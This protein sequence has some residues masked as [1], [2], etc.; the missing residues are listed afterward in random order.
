MADPIQIVVTDGIAQTIAPNLQGVANAAIEANDATVELQSQITKFGGLTSAAS[1]S[2]S[3][4]DAI[5]ASMSAT[6][7]ALNPAFVSV[8]E[9]TVAATDAL[10]GYTQAQ[11]TSLQAQQD[12]LNFMNALN[13]S[14]GL[15]STVTKSA[16]DSAKILS[17]ALDAE[18]AAFAAVAE[19]L[20]VHN[21]AILDG[22]DLALAYRASILAAAEADL[23]LADASSV[24][25]ASVLSTADASGKGASAFGGLVKAAAAFFAITE[26]VKAIDNYTKLTNA[27]TLAGLSGQNAANEFNYLTNLAEDNGVA[28]A[29]VTSLYTK[30]LVIQGQ[31]HLS[32]SDLNKI[33][34]SLTE[35]FRI[36]GLGSA[37]V[38]QTLRDFT[39]IL[40]GNNT[41]L[42]R[43]V[44][45]LQRADPA[46]FNTVLKQL[47]LSASQLSAEL[48]D[49]TLSIANFA[50]AVVQ[51]EPAMQRLAD[52]THITVTGALTDLQ[53]A[54]TQL[55]S[56]A[57]NSTGAISLV[58]QSIQLL[59]EN[60]PLVATLVTVFGAAWAGAKLVEVAGTLISLTKDLLALEITLGGVD[61]GITIAAVEI[62][63]FVAVAALTAYT[64]A[65]V[66]G[67]L[68]KFNQN[69]AAGA[70]FVGD[71]AKQG[72]AQASSAFKGLIGDVENSTEAT[73]TF[74]GVQASASDAIAKTTTAVDALTNSTASLSSATKDGSTEWGVLNQNLDGSDNYFRKLNSDITEI[75]TS[76]DDMSASANTAS[77]QLASLANYKAAGNPFDDPSNDNGNFTTIGNQTSFPD[78]TG[79]A[80]AS[81]G[82]FIVGGSPGVDTNQVRFK[83]T[84][85]ER[86]TVTT[87]AQQKA[88]N[89]NGGGNVAH[90]YMTVNATDANSFRKS[91]AQ[92]A[93]DLG[94]AIQAG[95]N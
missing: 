48:K 49:G 2:A 33:V 41:N 55:V 36:Q 26:V 78:V 87:P 44:N 35:S 79:P 1:V 52:V 17:A 18:D 61:T 66:T 67:N 51:S 65:L 74:S 5:L 88:A 84:A 80:F 23:A 24:A 59:A 39:D 64:I 60:L 76:L 19:S 70:A 63:A 11:I 21:A 12:G 95:M 15:N 83:A 29:S 25:G 16:A 56:N 13:E 30:L 6:T 14:F 77:Q 86:V 34:A 47:G 28:I 85:G 71:F 10:R 46:L 9:G 43:F 4:F 54:F 90:V 58:A 50:Q 38:T 62:L 72:L 57:Q 75:T 45:N 69:I 42:T 20:T 40:E 3:E 73:G 91:S 53:T 8:A 27:I 68:D 81:G 22:T 94:S 82:S 37:Q 93:R 32:T 7:R 92:I 89:G 31:L